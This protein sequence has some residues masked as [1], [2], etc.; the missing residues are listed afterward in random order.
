MKK[1]EAIIKPYKVEEIKNSLVEVGVHGMTVTML[2]DLVLR[3]DIKKTTEPLKLQL[4]SC[5]KLK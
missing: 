1:I 3:A 2:R 4:V 5:P